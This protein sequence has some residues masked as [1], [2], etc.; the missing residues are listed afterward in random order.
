MDA[1]FW[2]TRW[3]ENRLGFHESEG[4][5]LFRAQFGALN[6]P[7]GGCVFVPLAGKSQDIRYLLG[8]GYRVSAVEL[9]TQA[10]DSWFAEHH[11]TPAITQVGTLARY[12]IHDAPG[13][14]FWAGDVFD[15]TPQLLG[16]VDAVYDR[17]A[18][19]ALP[20][21]MRPAYAA[22]IH[23]L[24]RGAL[25][26]LLCFEYDQSAMPGPPFS[27]DRAEIM[28]V[29]GRHYALQE[30]AR[31]QMPVKLKNKVEAQEV[32]WRLSAETKL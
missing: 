31:L 2:H 15:L 23:R 21:S 17:A 16:P 13:L 4:N 25:Q 6:L 30:L 20:E 14:V 28:R 27:V 22:H 26:L 3:A 7:P 10:V 18:L 11:L 24:T 8:Q 1:T 12:D 5:A 29:Y 32:A 19:V 9:S